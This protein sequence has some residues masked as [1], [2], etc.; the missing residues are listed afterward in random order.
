MR[1]CHEIEGAHV[2]DVAFRGS[3]AV[4][5]TE[6][7]KPWGEATSCTWCGKCVAVCPTGALTYHGRAVGEMQHQTDIV[8]R[9]AKARRSGEW[10]DPDWVDGPV[11][12]EVR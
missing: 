8:I 12:G 2:W 4:L 6:M 5:V 3:Q 9:L 10:I 7:G 11:G 1:V